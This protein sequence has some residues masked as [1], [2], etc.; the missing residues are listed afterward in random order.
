MIKS[1][2]DQRLIQFLMGLNDGYAQ[3]RGNILMIN[4]LP[5]IS[6]TYSL[7]LQDENQREVYMNPHYPSNR[8]SFM[9]GNQTK[10]QQKFGNQIQRF[11]NQTQPQ[12][13]YGNQFQTQRFQ[14]GN[15]RYNPNQRGGKGRKK[16][17]NPNVTCTNCLKTG[18]VMDNCYRLIGYPDDFQFT[19]NKEHVNVKGNAAITDEKFGNMS[20]G[21]DDNDINGLS[22]L[23]KDQVSQIMQI[24]KQSQ[25]GASSSNTTKINANT[26][27]GTITRYFGSCFSVYNT[28]SWIVDS[29]ASEHM[30]FNSN[31][32]LN[33]TPLPAPLNINLPNS[34]RI[35]VTHTGSV[36]V[37]PKIVLQNDH[38]MRKVQAFGE[39]RE[40]L[41]VLEPT[42]F[43]NP[44]L[45]QINVVN[46][47]EGNYSSSGQVSKS[48]PFSASAVSDVAIWH[49]SRGTWTFLLT[50]KNNAFP[51]LKNFLCIVERQFDVKVK[52][53]RS[54]NALELG[55]GI[56]ESNFL[57]S[58]GII[59][60][61]SCTATPQQ[62]GIVE[63]KHRHLLEISRALL[64]QS[65]LPIS[66]WGEC[67][68]TA[69]HLINRL[70]SSVL[71][72][73]SPY[74]ILFGKPPNYKGLK[75][76]GC[77]CY[78]STL[79]NNRGKF[80]PRARACVFLETQATDPE[81]PSSHIISD[82]EP[83][84]VIIS[85]I[86]PDQR[87][88][89]STQ[90]QPER[91]STRTHKRPSYLDDFI[92]NHVYLT[93]V[94]SNCFTQPSQPSTFSFGDLS[95]QNQHLLSYTATITEPTSF[96]QASMNP[97]WL[98]AMDKEISALQDNDTWEVVVLP[99]DR[100]ALPSKWVYKV[101][102]NSDG[103]IERL[104]ARLVIRGDI[105]R[106]GIDYNE[107]FSQWL[108]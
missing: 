35:Q 104:K 90:I 15:Q 19:N 49:A 18:H 71:K 39:V 76:F 4:P 102:Q 37:L 64:F 100:K 95:L 20:M 85:D 74:H 48:F 34:Y 11:G 83:P 89:T 1:V 86:V 40:G 79:K 6:H 26:V 75:T 10:G 81:I 8:S 38:L 92:C 42:D 77:L 87:P 91:Q 59:H 24:F 13:R 93:D 66:Y 70:P 7:L 67:V 31:S 63:R 69:T 22:Q 72:G 107:T 68:L 105:Q 3:A 97:G 45:S 94:S 52:K 2:E 41:Y 23:S 106:E 65:K 108:R 36:Q 61:T 82:P 56:Q 73:K 25:N 51:I 44:S 60:E 29:G 55:K 103:T 80:D 12:Q 46:L 33:L 5:S 47:Q 43:R 9:T 54:D 27:A 32:F 14:N 28:K 98:Q 30:C 84:E 99:L 96:K 101:K 16:K 21:N 53:I 62:N 57:Q 88:T 50:V 58:Q 17:Y 78:A